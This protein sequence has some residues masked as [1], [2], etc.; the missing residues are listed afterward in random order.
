MCARFPIQKLQNLWAVQTPEH[1]D[2]PEW[3]THRPPP[4]R[5]ESRPAPEANF[6]PTLTDARAEPFFVTLPLNL[7]RL[8]W[9]MIPRAMLTLKV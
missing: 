2:V 5:L 9:V 3:P 7:R 6:D 4:D 8:G 1:R